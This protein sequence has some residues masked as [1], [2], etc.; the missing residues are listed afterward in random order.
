MKLVFVYG[1]LKRG[2][3]N[4]NFL[5]GQAFLGDAVTGPGY[6]LY[7]LGDYPGMVAR[8]GSAGAITGEVWSVDAACL[9]QLDAL[10]GT[11]E[12][13]YRRACVPLL[14]PFADRPVETYIYLRGVE[15]RPLVGTAWTK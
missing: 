7:D 2:F 3:A 1:T 9:A 13:M 14:A 15:G 10:E 6:A 11:A 8:A 5:A 12:E 4:H